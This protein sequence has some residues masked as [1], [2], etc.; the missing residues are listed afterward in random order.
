MAL[1]LPLTGIQK[2]TCKP[3]FNES[4]N[5]SYEFMDFI[6]V[7]L[8]KKY[9]MTQTSLNFGRTQMLMFISKCYRISKTTWQRIDQQFLIQSYFITEEYVVSEPGP[10]ME[11]LKNFFT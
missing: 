4:E 5:E 11:R 6:S 3:I 7:S 9:L 8:V 1:C 2:K 10:T